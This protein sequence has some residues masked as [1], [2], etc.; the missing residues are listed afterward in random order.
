[1]SSEGNSGIW[2][3]YTT[4]AHIVSFKSMNWLPVNHKASLNTLKYQIV[5]SAVHISHW[6]D[7]KWLQMLGFII[8]A[9][10]IFSK[11]SNNW[12]CLPKRCIFSVVSLCFNLTERNKD[13]VLETLD[14]NAD[15]LMASAVIRSHPLGNMNICAN[16]FDNP[17]TSFEDI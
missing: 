7:V 4:K 12:L 10:H 2:R 11:L 14:D 5:T 1:M 3:C 6:L 16:I 8:L 17:S 9:L 15:M 13:Q